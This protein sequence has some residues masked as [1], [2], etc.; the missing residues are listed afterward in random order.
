[1]LK[2]DG[3]YRGLHAIHVENGLEFGSKFEGGHWTI[4]TCAVPVVNALLESE[5]VSKITLGLIVRI[6][7][8]QRSQQ[9]GMQV[10]CEQQAFRVSIWDARVFQ[11]F[12]VVPASKKRRMVKELLKTVSS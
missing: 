8:T 11:L 3:M 5:Y 4:I 10:V 7:G 6:A 9:P 2:K 1:M 12:K